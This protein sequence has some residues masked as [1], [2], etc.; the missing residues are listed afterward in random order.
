MKRNMD[1]VRS[2]L[3]R[4]EDSPL[5]GAVPP[6]RLQGLTPEQIRYHVHLM[7]EDG[8]IEDAEVTPGKSTGSDQVPQVLTAKGHDFL[9]LARD[10]DRWNQAHRIIRK[11]G[12]APIAVWMQVLK[13]LLLK[14]L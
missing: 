7:A 11:V 13:D 12:S 5:G 4:I 14:D 1:L 3:M 10:R 9:D 6:F 8:L 2:I